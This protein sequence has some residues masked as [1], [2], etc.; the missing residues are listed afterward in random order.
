MGAV[1]HTGP[2]TAGAPPAAGAGP[3][4]PR[5][6]AA[7]EPGS[8]SGAAL[9][10]AFRS[11]TVRFCHHG[12]GDPIPDAAIHGV[13]RHPSPTLRFRVAFDD[14][15]STDMGLEEVLAAC[16][17]AGAPRG[18]G[19]VVEECLAELAAARRSASRDPRP[20][21]AAAAAV[22]QQLE[23]TQTMPPGLLSSQDVEPPP[24]PVLR[25]GAVVPP[26]KFRGVAWCHLRGGCWHARIREDNDDKTV[27]PATRSV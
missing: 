3:G 10:P 4:V 22:A 23:D 7:P 17:Q 13:I 1:A 18:G 6:A 8:R 25:P 15:T 5:T 14:G 26:R 24:P 21:L 16:V 9:A 11:G 19:S 12:S 27:R 20:R 2:Y